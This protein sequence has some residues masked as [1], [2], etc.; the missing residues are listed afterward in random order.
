M[1]KLIA[2]LITAILLVAVFSVVGAEGNQ[3]G[4]DTGDCPEGYIEE[5]TVG[6]ECHD[7]PVYEWQCKYAGTRKEWKCWLG[8]GWY[9]KQVGVEQVCEDVEICDCIEQETEETCRKRMYHLVGKNGRTC[10]LIINYSAGDVPGVLPERFDG[11][12]YMVE[13]CSQTCGG[14]ELST[15]EWTGQWYPVCDLPACQ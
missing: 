2:L 6:E 12:P 14:R 10:D 7:E 11:T 8:L 13:L 15:F 5:C 9:L 1:K 3:C 4:G